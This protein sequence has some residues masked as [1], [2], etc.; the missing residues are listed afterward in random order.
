MII[1][2]IERVLEHKRKFKITYY[3]KPYLKILSIDRLNERFNGLFDNII[4]FNW[5]GSIN[6]KI[7]NNEIVDLF[8]DVLYEYENRKINYWI[9]INR[10]ISEYKNKAYAFDMTKIER[11]LEKI[12]NK[13]IL[14]KYMD[15]QFIKFWENS[16]IRFGIA[17]SYKDVVLEQAIRDD[18][19]KMVKQINGLWMKLEKIGTDID[20]SGDKIHVIDGRLEIM[21][22]YPFYV[23]SFAIDVD[24][25]LFAL[26]GYDSCV[27]FENYLEYIE[28][29]QETIIRSKDVFKI[30]SRRVEYIDEN[31]QLKNEANLE[32]QKTISYKYQNEYRFVIELNKSSDRQELVFNLNDFAAKTYKIIK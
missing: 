32:F 28:S 3:E 13:N 8:L 20:I 2:E 1:K 5:D 30:H 6:F 9:N 18:E 14:V 15:P 27:I 10:R 25:K 29:V 24:P 21:Y 7:L 12:S 16:N 11:V 26:F 31:R 4:C 23:C 22:P 17:S 19:N